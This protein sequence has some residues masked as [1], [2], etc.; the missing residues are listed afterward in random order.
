MATHP[1]IIAERKRLR[2][3][4]FFPT[5]GRVLSH[6]R[7]G[8]HYMRVVEYHTNGFSSLY[9][10]AYETHAKARKA[11]IVP[12]NELVHLVQNVS[13]REYK[14]ITSRRKPRT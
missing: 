1:S 13:P 4:G 5:A 12:L 9:V 11:K 7:L 6:Q 3:L 10:E 14:A 2:R 8:A